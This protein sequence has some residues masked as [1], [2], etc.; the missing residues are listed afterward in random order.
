[1]VDHVNRKHCHKCKYVCYKQVETNFD[2]VRTLLRLS[3]FW[4]RQDRLLLSL[5]MSNALRA[6]AEPS[7]ILRKN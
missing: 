2:T 6:K 5:E 1:M 7:L 3:Y 4:C